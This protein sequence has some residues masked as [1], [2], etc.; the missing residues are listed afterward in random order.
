M[1]SPKFD[2]LSRLGSIVDD[3]AVDPDIQNADLLHYDQSRKLAPHE[4]KARLPI[5]EVL[6][7]EVERTWDR[8]QAACRDLQLWR[9]SHGEEEPS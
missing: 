4:M 3:G 7:R 5:A 1:T 9:L 2:R 6:Q 8:Y